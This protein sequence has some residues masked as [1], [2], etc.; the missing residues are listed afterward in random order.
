MSSKQN[1]LI[2]IVFSRTAH[3]TCKVFRLVLILGAQ[4]K[5]VM[6]LLLSLAALERKRGSTHHPECCNI[7]W[8]CEE[9]ERV[10][11]GTVSV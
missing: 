1:I 9:L 5:H 8:R 4:N 6:L 3:K 11:Y 10:K 7:L 2:L